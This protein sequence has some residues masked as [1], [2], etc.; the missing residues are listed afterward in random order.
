MWG[1]ADGGLQGVTELITC[2]RC[3]DPWLREVQAQIRN[4]NLSADNRAAVG[5]M[6]TA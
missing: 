2:E 6:V 1:E 4:G 5:A 3:A